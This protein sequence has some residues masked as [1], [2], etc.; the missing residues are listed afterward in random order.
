MQF[1]GY[2]IILGI[3]SLVILLV[4]FALFAKRSRKVNL[5]SPDK[6][7]TK[8]D[9]ILNTPP[10]ETMAAT[11]ADGEGITVYDYDEGE[12]VAAPFAEQI[13]DIL[14]AKLKADP[15]LAAL[16]VDLGT[17][18]TTG[19]L[20]VWVDGTKYEQIE[21]IPNPQLQTAIKEAVDKWNQHMDSQH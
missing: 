1:S 16:N 5:T 17:S 6:P 3:L 10:E 12:H 20:E 21:D 19:E 14:Q 8:P 7:D 13:E 11:L 4:V 15:Q 9:W 2:I 18:E